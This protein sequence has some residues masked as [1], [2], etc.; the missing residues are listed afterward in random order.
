MFAPKFF[1]FLGKFFPA[2]TVVKTETIFPA[3]IA[4]AWLR[5]SSLKLGLSRFSLELRV[6]IFV[7]TSL[8]F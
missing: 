8:N 6:R 7:Y 3:L 4:G 1:F 2:V 5:D